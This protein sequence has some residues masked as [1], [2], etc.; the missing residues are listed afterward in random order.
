MD[1]D[2]VQEKDKINNIKLFKTGTILILLL[3][4]LLAS[5]SFYYG[6]HSAIGNLFNYQY[7]DL[8]GSIFD[9]A[10]IMAVLYIVGE[11]FLK[12]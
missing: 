1:E 12:K 10:V 3:L 6:M 2:T 8:I 4:L 7:S 5:F 9:L 11:F